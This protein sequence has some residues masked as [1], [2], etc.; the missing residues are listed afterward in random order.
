MIGVYDY[1]YAKYTWSK[2][3]WEGRVQ[4]NLS[5]RTEGVGRIVDGV[6]R[7]GCQTERKKQTSLEI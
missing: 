4:S 7:C 6:C 5:L 3:A 1:S 2:Y